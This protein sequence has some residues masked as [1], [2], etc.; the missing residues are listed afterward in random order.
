MEPSWRLQAILE[1]L[2]S[3]LLLC[4]F[5]LLDVHLR[6]ACKSHIHEMCLSVIEESLLPGP[7]MFRLA[8]SSFML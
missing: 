6:E 3:L 1:V 5:G 2:E 4:P 7:S 8:H